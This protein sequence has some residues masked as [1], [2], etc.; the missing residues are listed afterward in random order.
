M[1]KLALSIVAVLFLSSCL[2]TRS[3]LG[4]DYQSQ[5]YSKKQADNQK[6]ASQESSVVKID[7]K[8]ELIRNLNGRVESLENQIVQMQK[9]FVQDPNNQ[10]IILLQ[11]SL[12]K[13]EAQITK[14]ET[15]L[16]LSKQGLSQA[17]AN[18]NKPAPNSSDA[19]VE[20]KVP[21][22]KSTPPQASG[23][24]S[25]AFDAAQ[26]YFAKK[27]FKNAI[28][29]YQKFVDANAKSKNKFVPEAKYKIGLSFEA[30]G[31]KDEA[32]SFYE[33]VAAQHGSTEFGKKAKAKVTK[34]KK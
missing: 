29:E 10:K 25:G 28:L 26:D 6:Q 22:A 2:K 7:D 13:M 30:M 27:D 20:V 4:G 1:I 9:A 31:L 19:K 12:V 16:A 11:E 21:P 32:T 15:D 23:K 33:E 8:D 17:S 34:T 3:E 18:D 5:V 14:L 24:N